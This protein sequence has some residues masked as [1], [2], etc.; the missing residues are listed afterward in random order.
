MRLA[1]FA[2]SALGMMACAP[3]AGAG[4]IK[5]C[6]A[7]LE[8]ADWQSLF[9]N[10]PIVVPGGTVFDYA[11]HLFN[12]L[13]DPRDVAHEKGNGWNV[14]TAEEARR[15][16]LTLQDLD[17]DQKNT[18][19]VVTLR[20]ITL[21]RALPCATVSASAALSDG[22]GWKQPVIAADSGLYFQVY[23]VIS[24]VGLS[25]EFDDDANPFDFAAARGELNASVVTTIDRQVKIP[26]QN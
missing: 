4:D 3:A 11:G 9:F 2:A 22:W 19:G 16:S 18:S 1:L 12:G 23:G 15:D 8:P 6:A 14:S 17:V 7:H 24:A 26:D 20:S 5:V 13:Q 25:T 10:G 21:T